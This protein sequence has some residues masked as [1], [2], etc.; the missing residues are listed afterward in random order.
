MKYSEI[1]D[2]VETTRLLYS[3]GTLPRNLSGLFACTAI[4]RAL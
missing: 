4:E 2:S 1:R 3:E